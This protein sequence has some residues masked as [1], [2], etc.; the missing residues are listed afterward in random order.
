MCLGVA[1]PEENLLSDFFCTQFFTTLTHLM[2]DKVE[3]R[4]NTDFDDVFSKFL[5]Q[6]SISDLFQ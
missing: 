3:D 4:W 5:K 1:G 2:D 6:N